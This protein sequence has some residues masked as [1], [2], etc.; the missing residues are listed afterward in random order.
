MPITQ[1]VWVNGVFVD[2][3]LKEFLRPLR[4]EAFGPIRDELAVC[5]DRNLNHLCPALA[6]LYVQ[7]RNVFRSDWNSTLREGAGCCFP[8]APQNSQD[9]VFTVSFEYEGIALRHCGVDENVT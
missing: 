6:A 5:S 7:N 9:Q 3:G 8:N 1:A 2:H 4:K